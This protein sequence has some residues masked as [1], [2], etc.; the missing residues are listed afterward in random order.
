[1]KIAVCLYGRFNNRHSKISGAEGFLEL[2]RLVEA[3]PADTFKF[4]IYSTDLEEEASI[5]HLFGTLGAEIRIE[6]QQDFKGVIEASGVNLAGYEIPSGFRSFENLLSFLYSRGESIRMM[7][8]Q[9]TE[10][11][12]DWVVISRLDSG[13]L[14][15]HNGRQRSRV[16]PLGF[17]KFLDSGSVYSAAWDQHNIGYADQWFVCS[18]EQ[19]QS[20]SE[21]DVSAR[22]YLKEGSSYLQM[23]AQGIP[24]SNELDEFSN[25]RL[26]E[27]GTKA[28]SLLRLPVSRGLNAHLMHKY[29]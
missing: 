11:E 17:N 19:A 2:K 6:P 5:R 3:H 15:R 26:K 20:L 9:S 21:M 24:D 1:M 4:W 18:R 22:T 29:F 12:F 23:L 13:Q 14:D 10:E 27:A 8:E 25:E 28:N 16:A 7:L